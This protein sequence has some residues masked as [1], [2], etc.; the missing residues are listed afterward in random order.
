MDCNLRRC[1]PGSHSDAHAA[2]VRVVADLIASDGVIIK[3][4]PVVT[5]NRQNAA[6]ALFDLR[7]VVAETAH[8]EA[9]ISGRSTIGKRCH[10]HAALEDETDGGI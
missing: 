2:V 10:E 7:D 9:D 8:S 4:E 6:N 3:L 5:M 1:Q